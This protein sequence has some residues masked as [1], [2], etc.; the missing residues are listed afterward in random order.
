M[1]FL[2]FLVG[3][4]NS[5]N[6]KLII[7][8]HVVENNHVISLYSHQNERWHAVTIN[9]R[10]SSSSTAWIY[11]VLSIILLYTELMGMS[12]NQNIAIQFPLNSRQGFK[13][14]P[15]C[16]LMAMN[17]SYLY[18]PNSHH[19]CLWEIAK[20]IKFTSYCVHLGFS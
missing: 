5:I 10:I 11:K 4:V 18:I 13:I 3:Q 17:Y 12:M 19:F 8:D 14:S 7:H 16:H 2:S 6:L 9:S 20:I 1:Y 15:W